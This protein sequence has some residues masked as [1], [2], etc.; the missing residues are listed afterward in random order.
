MASLW[1]GGE[2]ETY[3]AGDSFIDH[4]TRV[5]L[6]SEN[7]ST[8]EPL[9]MLVSYVIRVGVPNVNIIQ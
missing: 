8:T 2:L 1:E 9:R 7:T 6:R 4:G 5:H 3:A